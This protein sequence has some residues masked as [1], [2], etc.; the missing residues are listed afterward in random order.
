MA[1][2]LRLLLFAAVVVSAALAVAPR[3][4]AA[5]GSITV[6][7]DPIA[8]N[9]ITITTTGSVTPPGALWVGVTPGQTSC[10]S[11]A[12]EDRLAATTLLANDK[13]VISGSFTYVATFTPDLTPSSYL[14]CEYT[15]GYGDGDLGGPG[16]QHAALQSFTARKAVETI[17]LAASSPASGVLNKAVNGVSEDS[18]LGGTY[19]QSHSRGRQA[20]IPS[21]RSR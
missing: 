6:S 17:A 13:P 18:G 7:A 2:R 5:T 15:S 19:S 9:P 20:R 16:P 12:Q 4:D 1:T 10:P 14:V 8:T 21:G 11:L 3:A